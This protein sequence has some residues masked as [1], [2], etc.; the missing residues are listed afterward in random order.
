MCVHV[1][2]K[3]KRL[4]TIEQARLAT[5]KLISRFV[6]V[7]LSFFFFF[8]SACPPPPRALASR[9]FARRFRPPARRLLTLVAGGQRRKRRKRGA[10]RS[11]SCLLAHCSAPHRPFP[12]PF[13]PPLRAP[14]PADRRAT[15]RMVYVLCRVCSFCDVVNRSLGVSSRW[16]PQKTR[17]GTVLSKKIRNTRLHT[18]TGHRIVVP[19]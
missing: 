4:N 18:R 15:G 17:P 2:L 13:E 5:Q 19:S 9:P 3:K 12:L 8:P 1:F 14:F 16:L 11:Y 7:V 6:C 10:R